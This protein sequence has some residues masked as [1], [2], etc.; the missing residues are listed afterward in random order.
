MAQEFIAFALLGVA[1]FFLVKKFVFKQKKKSGGCG[2]GDCG[3]S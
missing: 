2:S 1:V 3:C